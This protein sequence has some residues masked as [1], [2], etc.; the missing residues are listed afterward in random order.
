MASAVRR[1]R[2]FDENCVRDQE[3][4]CAN[5]RLPV[6]TAD[7]LASGFLPADFAGYLA[8]CLARPCAIG[9]GTTRDGDQFHW[10]DSRRYLGT[11]RWGWASGAA[12]CRS[13]ARVGELP[14]VGDPDTGFRVLMLKP[15]KP[16][17]SSR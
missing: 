17:R 4:A 8:G 13:A 5:D 14:L 2:V 9:G 6:D 12:R 3:G 11:Q 15:G 10:A 1:K 16:P 7:A